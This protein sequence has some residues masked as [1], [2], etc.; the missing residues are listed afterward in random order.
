MLH[1]LWLWCQIAILVAQARSVFESRKTKFYHVQRPSNAK[2]NY[3]ILFRRKIFLWNWQISFQ[4]IKNHRCRGI[5][6]N[7]PERERER[8]SLAINNR[9]I[10]RQIQTNSGINIKNHKNN[11]KNYKK[12]KNNIKELRKKYLRKQ[13]QESYVKKNMSW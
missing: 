7:K 1:S 4:R 2:I 13:L 6:R 3:R 12:L 11:Y 10:C 8:Q 5:V 9:F